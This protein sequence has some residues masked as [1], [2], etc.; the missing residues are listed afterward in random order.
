MGSA[1]A[2]PLLRASCAGA[3]SAE[4]AAFRQWASRSTRTHR[5]PARI[6]VT[7]MLPLGDIEAE[8]LR[9]FADLVGAH[10]GDRAVVAID[11]NF[12]LPDVPR[13]E[14]SE[15]YRGLAELGLAE[16]SAGTAST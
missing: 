5:D 13:R 10:G 12:V 11:Q 16:A 4:E 14:L 9:R 8:K 6:A 15:L 3:G 1:K 2:D 7:V